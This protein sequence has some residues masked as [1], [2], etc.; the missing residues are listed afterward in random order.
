[1]KLDEAFYELLQ[2]QNVEV[3]TVKDRNDA[4]AKRVYPDY[5]NVEIKPPFRNRLTIR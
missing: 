3:A 2:N 1:M 5:F 4:D